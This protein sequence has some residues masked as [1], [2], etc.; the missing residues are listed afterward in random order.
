MKYKHSLF[1]SG[2]LKHVFYSR[3]AGSSDS[4][5]HVVQYARS[6]WFPAHDSRHLVMN[7]FFSIHLHCLNGTKFGHLTTRNILEPDVTF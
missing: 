3:S 2:F 1:V 4:A 7:N 6:H 5:P